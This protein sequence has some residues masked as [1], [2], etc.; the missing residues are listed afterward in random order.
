M[1][2]PTYISMARRSHTSTLPD[3][4]ASSRDSRQPLAHGVGGTLPDY[5]GTTPVNGPDH[6]LRRRPSPYLRRRR[7][8]PS[9]FLTFLSPHRPDAR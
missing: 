1:S 8:Y 2:T 5:D 4:G 7:E 6:N 9:S 3:D